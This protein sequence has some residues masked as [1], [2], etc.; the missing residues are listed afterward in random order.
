MK[1]TFIEYYKDKGFW[2][3]IPFVQILNFYTLEV[4]KS[5]ANIEKKPSWFIGIYEELKDNI[6]GYSSSYLNWNFERELQYI[7]KREKVFL[8][9]L[10]KTSQLISS[11]G[12]IIDLKEINTI[13]QNMELPDEE[14]LIFNKEIKSKDLIL[15]INIIEKMIN[16]EWNS[17]D[18]L[19]TYEGFE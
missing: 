6:L 18:Y 17:D 16:K 13:F 15:T 14:K 5:M 8:E 1:D 2:I 12:E 10:K 19:I 7:E 3:K 4:L 9:V 11:K